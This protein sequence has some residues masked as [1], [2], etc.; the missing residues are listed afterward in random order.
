MRSSL[1][2]VEREL[3]R[4]KDEMRR[5]VRMAVINPA[6]EMSFVFTCIAFTIEIQGHQTRWPA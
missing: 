6:V 4:I 2:E 1:N 5:I 3:R